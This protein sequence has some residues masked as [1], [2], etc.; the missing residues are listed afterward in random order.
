MTWPKRRCY[1]TRRAQVVR[2]RWCPRS[3]RSATSSPGGGLRSSPPHDRRVERPTEGLNL[4]VKEVKRC[5]R[6]LENLEHDRLRV[7]LRA[8]KPTHAARTQNRPSPRPRIE[9]RIVAGGSARTGPRPRLRRPVTRR[10]RA[11]SPYGIYDVASN[12]G[13]GSVGD[14]ADTA[15]VPVTSIRAWW[16]Q[17]VALGSQTRHDC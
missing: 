17:R 12:E 8:S 4:L 5:G 15:E 6:V 1:S 9:S 11:S 2:P 14:V 3:V 13:W 7:L 10:V 16:N